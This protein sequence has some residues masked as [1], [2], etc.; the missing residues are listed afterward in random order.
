MNFKKKVFNVSLFVLLV[1]S[2]LVNFVEASTLL[3]RG[4]NFNVFF[5][6]DSSLGFQFGSD[7]LF[8]TATSGNLN[9]STNRLEIYD[10]WGQ[11]IFLSNEN[12]DLQITSNLKTIKIEGDQK[13]D[14]RIIESGSIVSI[15]STN[16]VTIYWYV[17]PTIWLPILFILG[18]IG[19]I[20]MSGG[21]L[22]AVNEFK[23]KHYEKGLTNGIIYV[24][25]GFALVLAWLW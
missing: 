23:K 5:V 24:T 9:S 18:M 25:I 13:R 16:K 14:N 20:L 19:L 17:S 15:D 2:L 4:S 1:F 12:L 6:Q 3:V 7:Y 21:S 22:Y 10:T 8:L 11:F